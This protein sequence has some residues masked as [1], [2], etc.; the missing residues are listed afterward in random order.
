MQ[1]LK[2]S[3]YKE[4]RIAK[5][6]N[7]DSNWK[8]LNSISPDYPLYFEFHYRFWKSSKSCN[9]PLISKGRTIYDVNETCN[10]F[11]ICFA[12]IFTLPEITL[13]QCKFP[14][15]LFVK[16]K[17]LKLLVVEPF[18]VYSCCQ[19]SIPLKGFKK[20]PNRLPTTCSQSFNFAQLR[21]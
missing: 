2:K 18:D 9:F 8:K 20:L 13:T 1:K 10:L 15:N 7:R 12:S 6:Y 17:D 11:N 14:N 19:I 5:S 16:R 21:M 3:W 4:I